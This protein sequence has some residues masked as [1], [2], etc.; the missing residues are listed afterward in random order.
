LFLGGVGALALQSL[1]SPASA[2]TRSQDVAITVLESFQARCFSADWAATHEVSFPAALSTG[3]SKESLSLDVQWDDRLFAVEAQ[4]FA[5]TPDGLQVVTAEIPR[6][7]QLRATLSPQ[8][9]AVYTSARPM[10]LY[11]ADNVDTPTSTVVSV[12]GNKRTARVSLPNITSASSAWGAEVFAEWAV[13]EGYSYPTIVGVRSIGPNPVPAGSIVTVRVY[14][15]VA[16]LSVDAGSFDVTQDMRSAKRSTEYVLEVTND[17]P[18]GDTQSFQLAP[19]EEPKIDDVPSVSQVA[20][21]ALTS[22]ARF[23]A[24]ARSTGKFSVASVTPSGSLLSDYRRARSAGS[25][26]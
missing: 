9:S 8:T 2:A 26:V 18:A 3:A 10:G 12:S 15:D 21:V 6:S 19:P 1:P 5:D 17:I 14:R 7:G 11:P 22:P 13:S 16:A 23:Q 4:V 20:Y 25:N 24:A